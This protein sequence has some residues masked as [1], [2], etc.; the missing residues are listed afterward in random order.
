MTTTFGRS[1]AI[2]AEARSKDGSS[3]S[4]MRLHQRAAVTELSAEGEGVK[5]RQNDPSSTLRRVELNNANRDAHAE[6]GKAHGQA[7]ALRALL[8]ITLPM[9]HATSPMI[10]AKTIAQMGTKINA[11]AEVEELVAVPPQSNSQAR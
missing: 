11:S 4:F 9:P 6:P 8:Q 2:K 5:S 10:L 7:E 3:A 1:D